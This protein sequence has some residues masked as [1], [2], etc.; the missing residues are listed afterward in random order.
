MNDETAKETLD[1]IKDGRGC[2]I[3]QAEI[4]RCL[5]HTGDVRANAR[6][7]SEGM[8]NEVRDQ[9]WRAR[10]RERQILVGRSRQ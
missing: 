4:R 7:G 2:Y 1:K 3:P 8:G 10:V 6:D 9:D 5:I